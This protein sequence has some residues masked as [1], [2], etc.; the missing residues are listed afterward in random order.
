VYTGVFE[1]GLDGIADLQ[2][3]DEMVPALVALGPFA[4]PQG[5]AIA[6]D[7]SGRGIWTLSEDPEGQ[8]LQPLHHLACQ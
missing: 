2:R 7:D 4:E 3:L 8:G 1:F 6:Y 5:E